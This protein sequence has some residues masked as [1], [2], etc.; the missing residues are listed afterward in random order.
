MILH[1]LCH[2]ISSFYHFSCYHHFYCINV[3]AQMQL[4]PKSDLG[5]PKSDL[6]K[7]EFWSS[8]TPNLTISQ[9]P[10]PTWVNLGYGLV[11]EMLHQTNHIPN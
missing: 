5:Y 3:V 6:N 2:I 7:V 10:K 8:D 9:R 1:S 4:C 11:W